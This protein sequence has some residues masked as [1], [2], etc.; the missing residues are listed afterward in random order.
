MKNFFDSHLYLQL[1]NIFTF[2]K[3]TVANLLMEKQGNWSATVKTWKKHPKEKDFKKRICIFTEK[4]TLGQFSVPAWAN[5]LPGFSLWGM[6][7]PNG[8][9]QTIKILLGYTKRLRE[10]KHGLLSHLKFE[11]LELFVNY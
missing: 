7:T 10:K 11:N 2:K 5:K 1:K 4:F 8:L 6:S 3:S 9:F